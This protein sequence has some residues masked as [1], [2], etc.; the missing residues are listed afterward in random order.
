MEILKLKDGTEVPVDS[1]RSI[2]HMVSECA[3]ETAAVALCGKFTPENLE[4][5]SVSYNGTVTETYD[6]LRCANPPA[7]STGSD[8]KKVNVIISL[9]ERNDVEILED[10]FK[11]KL[12]EKE[13]EITDLQLAMAEMYEGGA[14]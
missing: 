11:V 5:V 9:R 12:A 13:Q 8:G 14:M 2:F 10:T 4:Q 1:A 3:D 6:H 7:R